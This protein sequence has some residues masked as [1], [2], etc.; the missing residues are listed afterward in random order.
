[1]RW[2]RR[3]SECRFTTTVVLG[4]AA[5]GAW[6]SAPITAGTTVSAVAVDAP[7]PVFATVGAFAVPPRCLNA[8]WSAA[9]LAYSDTLVGGSTSR[10]QPGE[11]GAVPLAAAKPASSSDGG[12]DVPGRDR[13]E[14]D[15]DHRAAVAGCG[16]DERVLGLIRVAGL[17]AGDAR[18]VVAAPG[19]HPIVV[20]Q[21]V[22]AAPGR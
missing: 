6:S 13:T 20:L 3:P 7:V 4:D 1:M 17:E 22:L 8:S 18:V 9:R 11:T 15:R 14:D 21:G 12:L 16:R 5:R 19:Q 2:V 10:P